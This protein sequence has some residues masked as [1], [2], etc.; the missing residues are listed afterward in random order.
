MAAGYP[1]SCGAETGST[2]SEREKRPIEGEQVHGPR[3][4]R[5]GLQ[6][7]ALA[8]T[9]RSL[10]ALISSAIAHERVLIW[11]PGPGRLDAAELIAT[12]WRSGSLGPWVSRPNDNHTSGYSR[13]ARTASA[14]MPG[15]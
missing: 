8:A 9:S 3:S 2:P 12:S 5:F 6:P 14:T 15:S 1:G 10:E 7:L 11:T 4:R 13:A